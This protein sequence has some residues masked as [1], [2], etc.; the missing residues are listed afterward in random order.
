ME[1]LQNPPDSAAPETRESEDEPGSTRLLGRSTAID[2]VL[3]LIARVAPTEA[4]VLICGESGSGKELVARSIHEGS[5]RR[6][7]PFV[8]INCGA[9]PPTLIESELFGYEKGSFTGAV[10]TH[11]GLI[12]R[13]EGG[14]LF[15]D[16]VTEMPIDL[17]VRLLRFLETRSF[18]RIGGRQPLRSDLRVIAATNRNP[19]QAVRAGL[20]REDL[21]YRLAV[22]PIDV[23]PLRAR[24]SDAVLLG[25]HFLEELNRAH[26]TAKTFSAASGAALRAHAWPGNVREL[27]NAV[28]R[29]FI[30]SDDVL[31][32]E[33]DPE[34]V[35]GTAAGPP[36][37]RI[38]IGTRLAEVE[39][40]LIEAT[41]GHF[42]GNKRKTADVLGCSLKT[43]YN[44]LAAYQRED[45]PAAI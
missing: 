24:G 28:E 17:Q 33:P 10:G 14:T 22:F 37:L 21:L 31:E 39:R 1:K 30:L 35:Q 8:A 12:E 4:T 32:L 38:P 13:A 27:R 36:E 2:A 44:K 40:S 23:P 15:L 42:M 18:Y 34:P 26:G 6:A 7:G 29:A 20:L 11:S 43:L 16:E 41:L 45:A 25:R 3:Q 9:L 5:A 19:G